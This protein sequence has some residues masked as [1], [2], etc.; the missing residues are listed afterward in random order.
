MD[1]GGIASSTAPQRQEYA[2]SPQ[3]ETKSVY[4][5][6]RGE[7]DAHIPLVVLKKSVVPGLHPVK[8]DVRKAAGSPAEAG[9]G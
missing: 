7:H 4:E 9:G 3:R 1:T 5:M 8:A 6:M 2:V